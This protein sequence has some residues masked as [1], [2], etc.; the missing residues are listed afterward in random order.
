M[1]IAVAV[2]LTIAGARTHRLADFTEQQSLTLASTTHDVVN[3][4]HDEVKV[5]AFIGRDDA[6]RVE[7]VTLLDRYA[8]LNRH[9]HTDV[10]EVFLTQDES[11]FQLKKP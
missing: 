7:A 8:R 9:V 3:A 4:V 5:T 6:G 11:K 10:V 2:A 1:L